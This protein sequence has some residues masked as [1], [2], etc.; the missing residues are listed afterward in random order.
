MT[1]HWLPVGPSRTSSAGIDGERDEQVRITDDP[2]VDAAYAHLTDERL[3]PG[4]TLFPVELPE[5]VRAIVVL[6]RKDGKAGTGGG[7]AAVH[8]GHLRRA[9]GH[10][11]C[12][13]GRPRSREPRRRPGP[14]A[15]RVCPGW[16][17][18][19]GPGPGPGPL[20]GGIAT[21]PI[22]AV[23]AGQANG[24]AG[25]RRAEYRLGRLGL[26]GHGLSGAGGLR[27]RRGQG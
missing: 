27:R 19:A 22:A 13:Q 15:T 26:R 12:R 5:G 2:E 14:P 7:G 20:A 9:P 11:A 4:L 21:R 6:D 3:M 8:G 10:V 17:L 16:S 24:P 18:S 23:P 25:E 1:A